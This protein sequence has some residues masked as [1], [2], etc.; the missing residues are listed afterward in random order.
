[1]NKLFTRLAASLKKN[2]CLA[3][4]AAVLQKSGNLAR[5]GTAL[6]FSLVTAG[7]VACGGLPLRLLV[8]VV[9]CIGLLEFLT[10][11]TGPA[12]PG[13][14]VAGIALCAALILSQGLDPL[15]TLAA[16]ALAA[17]AAGLVVIYDR[18]RGRN[19]LSA[20]DYAPLFFGTAYIPLTLQLGLYLAPAEQFMV[21]LCAAASDTGGYY[22]GTLFGRHKL[23]PV[24]SPLKSWE[25]FGGGL[26]L[27]TA[28]CLLMGAASEHLQWRFLHLPLWAWA[29]MGAVLHCAAVAG[30]LFESAVKRGLGRKDSGSLLPGHG[31]ML[32]RIDSFLFVLPTYMLIRVVTR[33]AQ[34]S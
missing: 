8:L 25:G 27:C 32:D 29:L 26:V 11:H 30:D 2:A 18:I 23:C 14:K 13:L 34:G 31:G 6:V 9:A 28:V 15:I 10:M 20:A 33:F 21:I 22:A 19:S 24:I 5:I 1:M 12:R 3:R 17:P 16:A 4:A 7:A